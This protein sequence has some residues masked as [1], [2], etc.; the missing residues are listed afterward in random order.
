MP[1]R[2]RIAGKS[3]RAFLALGER[4]ENHG[5]ASALIAERAARAGRAA[6]SI[7]LPQ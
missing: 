6:R 7:E 3:Y 1:A 5:I 4:L 2:H